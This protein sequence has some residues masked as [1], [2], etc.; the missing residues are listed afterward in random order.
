MAKTLTAE[1]IEDTGVW[2]SYASTLDHIRLIS[3]KRAEMEAKLLGAQLEA[4]G[5]LVHRIASDYAAG[6]LTERD[7]C[8]IYDAYRA[9]ANTGFSRLWN[10]SL[11][12]SAPQMQ[13]M[14]AR[15]KREDQCAVGSWSGCFPFGDGE[16][17]PP[18]QFSVVYVLFD[19][20]NTPCYVG[21][22]ENFRSRI[23]AHAR[24]GK[25]FVRWSAHPCTDRESAYQLEDR[26]LHEHKP[27]LNRRTGR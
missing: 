11:P 22:T 13:H 24:E 15:H 19:A 27:Y 6:R 2:D 10:A 16:P 12:F 25:Q 8:E 9:V 20:R 23:R 17:T 4:E 26:L 3:A 1:A 5:Q 18:Y 14:K 21:S 7:L